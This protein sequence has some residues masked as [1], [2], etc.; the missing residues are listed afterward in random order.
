MAGCN[1]GKTWTYSV[2]TI[3]NVTL[4]SVTPHITAPN[5]A[6]LRNCNL[7]PMAISPHEY[8]SA[9]RVYPNP[10]STEL[11]IDVTD[12]PGGNSYIL[13]DMYGKVAWKRECSEHT[14][15]DISSLPGSVYLLTINNINYTRVVKE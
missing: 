12:N 8:K 6:P 13:M 4:V 14:I 15:L 11:H 2:D 10:A 3:C 9:A 7:N 1:N 5:P